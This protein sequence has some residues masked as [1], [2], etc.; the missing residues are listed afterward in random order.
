MADY[1]ESLDFAVRE[2]AKNMVGVGDI[3]V[4]SS[5]KIPAVEYKGS[6]DG[7][8]K[9]SSKALKSRLSKNYSFDLSMRLAVN[10]LINAKA[11]RGIIYITQGRL[12]DSSF[13][14]YGISDLTSY[15]NNNGISFSVVQLTQNTVVEEELDYIVKKANGKFYYVYRQ[16]GLSNV[17]TDMLEIPN[18]LYSLSYTSSLPTDLG[19]AYLPVEIETYVLNRSGRDETGYFSPLK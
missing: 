5:S 8:L 17:V 11:K 10:E 4:I 14:Q 19:R 6:P 12:D 18:G 16:Q 13:E 9:F 7:L 1:S 3:T 2:I 15:M